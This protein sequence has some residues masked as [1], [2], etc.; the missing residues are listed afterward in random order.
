GALADRVVVTSI[1]V[2]PNS[3]ETGSSGGFSENHPVLLSPL[4][5]GGSRVAWTDGT[6]TVHITPLDARDQRA[7]DDVTLPGDEVRGFVAHDVGATLLLR[8]GDTM[9]LVQVDGH[10]AAVFERVLAG[11]NSHGHVGD[12][13][14]DS[15]S[16]EGRLAAT[17]T[18][19]AAYFGLTQLWDSGN[20]QGDALHYFD[21]A[22]TSTGGGWT[23]GCSHSLDVRLAYS[24]TTP[25]P[26]CLSDCYPG[27]GI[28]FDHDTRVF[29]DPSGNCAGSSDTVLGG[30][31][32][33]ADGFLPQRCR[34]SHMKHDRQCASS[35]PLHAAFL[36]ASK[37]SSNSFRT[38]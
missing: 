38:A 29:E 17:D 14:I 32:A 2:S 5:D 27:K 8:R 10:G 31:V 21:I 9:V 35:P 1:D 22:G 23:W 18:R 15:W 37:Y 12:Q 13:W 16:H 3:V 19:F 33:V 6:G 28:Y 4:A 7:G 24:G 20:H 30:L 26:V 34:P 36:N 25:G 11:D